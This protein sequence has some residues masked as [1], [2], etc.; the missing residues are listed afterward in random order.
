ML[1]FTQDQLIELNVENSEF[2]K[3][4]LNNIYA[5]LSILVNFQVFRL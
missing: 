5:V 2:L 1:N 3:F 4:M